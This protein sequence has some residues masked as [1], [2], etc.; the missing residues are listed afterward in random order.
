MWCIARV[1]AHLSWAERWPRGAGLAGRCVFGWLEHWAGVTRESVGSVSGC[2]SKGYV[3]CSLVSYYYFYTCTCS[4][5]NCIVLPGPT[6]D[7]WRVVCM[8]L[9]LF[10]V[11]DHFFYPCRYKLV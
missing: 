1:A 4:I 11:S 3:I 2:C 5:G 7:L 9:V 6:H 8:A 10:S